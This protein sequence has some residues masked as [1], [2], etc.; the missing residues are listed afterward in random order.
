FAQWLDCSDYRHHTALKLANYWYFR[1][2]TNRAKQF[3]DTIVLAQRK[4][5][6]QEILLHQNERD[7]IYNLLPGP[8]RRC[9][10]DCDGLPMFHHYSWVR[11]YDEMLKKVRSWGHKNDRDW[12]SLV[13]EE[14]ASPFRGTDFVHG[15]SYDIVKPSF[16]IHL[17]EPV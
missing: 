2:P 1:E 11:T 8:K 4:A 15:Y 6:D 7:A 16:D 17:N 9:V 13:H 12:S 5:L 10:T 14:F 3:E